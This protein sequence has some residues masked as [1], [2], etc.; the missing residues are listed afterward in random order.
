MG[1]ALQ[2]LFNDGMALLRKAIPVIPLC[3]AVVA[4]YFAVY[5]FFQVFGCLVVADLIACGVHPVSR[6]APFLPVDDTIFPPLL[7][8]GARRK[9]TT[10]TRSTL[11]V[12]S[13]GLDA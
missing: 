2:S 10:C 7:E 6:C 1:F 5:S 4:F 9:L 8:C 12:K 3:P 13:A 11:I